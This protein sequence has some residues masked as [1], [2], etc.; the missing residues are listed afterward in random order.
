MAAMYPPDDV[1]EKR[2]DSRRIPVVVFE[3][4]GSG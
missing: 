3:P 2:A 4:I 1:C